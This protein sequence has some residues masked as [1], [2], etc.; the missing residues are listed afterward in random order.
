M[1]ETN[2]ITIP[3]NKLLFLDKK[4]KVGWAKY[5]EELEINHILQLEY[6]NYIKKLE[7][8]LNKKDNSLPSH[9]ITEMK[10]MYSKLH[11]KV[12]CPICLEEIQIDNIIWSSCKCKNKYCKGCYEK[13]DKCAICRGKIYK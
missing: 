13:I 10:D 5:Y 9:L 4:A 1:S 7:K 6:V 3:K 12:E 11:K 8:Q 2:L